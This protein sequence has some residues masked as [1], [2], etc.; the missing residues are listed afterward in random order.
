VRG[1]AREATVSLETVLD[2]EHRSRV[3]R[4]ATMKRIADAPALPIAEVDEF[5]AA[6]TANGEA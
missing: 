4:S 5:R 3:L 6:A 1:L 2:L